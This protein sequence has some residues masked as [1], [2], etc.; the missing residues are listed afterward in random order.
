MLLRPPT[1]SVG[2]R[3]DTKRRA[4]RWGWAWLLAAALPA[5]AADLIDAWR[6]AQQHD[7][8]VVAAREAHRAG[9]TRRDQASGL[10]RP[11]LHLSAA[12]GYMTQDT[13]THGARFQAPGFGRSDEVDFTTSVHG[14]R[15]TGWALTARQA[16]INRE[17]DAQSRQLELAA[18][19][20]DHEW[21][22]AQQD[23]ILRVAER[24]F[25]VALA[26][27]SLR[28]LHAQQSAV[29]K[30]AA[31][32]RE[33]FEQGS[34]PIT[35][36]H[37][38]TARAEA[39]KAQVLAGTTELQLKQSALADMTGWHAE[40]GPLAL[41]FE[42]LPSE[43]LAGL[44]QCLAAGE[45]GNPALAL[46]ATAAASAREEAAKFSARA[47]PTLDLVARLGDERLSGDGDFGA[48]RNLSRS[49]SIGLQL[50]VPLWTGGVRGAR[51]QEAL[52]LSEKAATQ[53][54][55]TRQQV[56]L[57]IRTAWLGLTTGAG[58]LAALDEALTASQAR[59]EAT[60]LGHQVGDRTTLELLNAENDAAS[61]ALML[62]EGRVA[63]L[64]NRLRLASLTGQLGEEQ[65]RA[66]NATLR[67]PDPAP[68]TP[69][70]P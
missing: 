23:L 70:R 3:R 41:P 25:D 28:L 30:A 43:P 51:E 52:H 57:Q 11:S 60:R 18:Q 14:G 58:R 59:L 46:Q 8:D 13:E 37:E 6:A 4:L 65:L 15:S 38:T 54:A 27:E 1:T 26:A 22:T 31:E 47:A 44:D 34:L 63:L 68:E 39:I 33:R 19:A 24:Y 2:Q 20:A 49:R 61:A 16:L 21:Q 48:S 53:A 56:A 32:A 64:L 55:R 12:A 69:A 66:I 35:D 45:A 67:P 36:V 42:A 9:Q 10:W 7:L 29:A 5:Q 50:N 62:A 17:R 40:V